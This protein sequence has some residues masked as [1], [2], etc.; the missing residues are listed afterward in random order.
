[1]RTLSLLAALS[2]I[3]VP[4]LLAQSNVITQQIAGTTYYS[5][6]VGGSAI[7]GTGQ[8]VGS[9]TYYNLNVA[10]QPLSLTRQ[11]VGSQVYGSDG[12]ISQ[13]IGAQSY[14]TTPQG[15]SY[16]QQA[17]GNSVYTSGSNG[18]M[19]STQILGAQSY[20]TGNC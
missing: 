6:S 19:S 14:T 18:C 4:K 1:M 16:T 11:A 17:I 7:W 15:S 10:G 13:R 5:G 3:S 2:L 9:T 20:T 12:S 8:Q